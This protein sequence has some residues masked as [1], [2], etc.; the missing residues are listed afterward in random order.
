MRQVRK[1]L[2]RL[3]AVSSTGTCH[4]PDRLVVSKA[5]GGARAVHT[6]VQLASWLSLN[7]MRRRQISVGRRL[8]F[9]IAL[10]PRPLAAP[11]APRHPSAGPRRCARSPPPVPPHESIRRSLRPRPHRHATLT[12][13][14]NSPRAR[15]TTARGRATARASG[16]F[17]AW[18]AAAAQP[19][20][21][22]HPPR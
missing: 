16:A 19:P 14:R 6:L 11:G 7:G 21:R 13:S 10:H 4:R 20:R 15:A 3:L 2:L 22:P 1:A 9:V 18:A 5:P 12:R 17:S 8:R